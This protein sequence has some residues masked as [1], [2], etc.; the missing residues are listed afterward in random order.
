METHKDD[1]G[2]DAK[3]QDRRGKAG[4]CPIKGPEGRRT[5]QE[6]LIDETKPHRH[7]LEEEHDLRLLLADKNHGGTNQGEGTLWVPATALA[8][9]GPQYDP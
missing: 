1:S 8:M 3:R 6:D 4:I 5:K 2:E 7:H 9:T